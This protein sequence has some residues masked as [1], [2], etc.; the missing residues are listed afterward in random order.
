MVKLPSNYVLVDCMDGVCKQTSGYIVS[1][2]NYYAFVDDGFAVVVDTTAGTTFVSSK[3]AV[4]SC[5]VGDIG[6]FAANAGVIDGVCTKVNGGVKFEK[7]NKKYLITTGTDGLGENTP[8]VHANGEYVPV[9]HSLQ[10]IIRD[11]FDSGK[12]LSNYKLI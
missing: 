1:G 2:T 11:K 8:F 5:A 12:L 7:D 4:E 9:K 10:Y 3:N 6:K